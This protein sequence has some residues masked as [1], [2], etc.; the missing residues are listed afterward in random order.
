MC[1]SSK[2]TFVC[3]YITCQ[4]I[5]ISPFWSA[6]ILIH[7]KGPQTPHCPAIK[8]VTQSAQIS[9]VYE[10]ALILLMHVKLLLN[11]LWVNYLN[12]SSQ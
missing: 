1:D 3:D 12:V 4:G 7:N 2:N 6:V 9:S 10:S 5:C 11:S 8:A